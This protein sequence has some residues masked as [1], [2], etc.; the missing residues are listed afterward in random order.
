MTFR[1]IDEQDCK[2][3]VELQEQNWNRTVKKEKEK[4]NRKITFDTF[5]TFVLEQINFRMIW[6]EFSCEFCG[7]YRVDARWWTRQGRGRRREA[8]SGL[9]RSDKGRARLVKPW[10]R[11][12]LRLVRVDRNHSGHVGL[13]CGGSEGEPGCARIA[14]KEAK[15]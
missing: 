10:L 12:Q 13:W 4:S 7:D 8:P 15:F 5:D 9:I 2:R 11:S 14:Y 6:K 1:L 3:K